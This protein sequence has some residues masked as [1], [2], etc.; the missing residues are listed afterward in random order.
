MRYSDE[1][2][3][4]VNNN[5]IK[6]DIGL[7]AIGVNH[8]AEI[9]YDMFKDE[10]SND[11]FVKALKRF[12]TGKID[13]ETNKALIDGYGIDYN[14]MS[15]DIEKIKDNILN[16]NSIVAKLTTEIEKQNNSHGGEYYDDES[17]HLM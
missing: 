1:V 5:N 7:D 17:K 13:E 14:K 2:Y 12:Y 4:F 3:N 15:D 9:Y 6:L 11:N 16:N 8:L 10:L